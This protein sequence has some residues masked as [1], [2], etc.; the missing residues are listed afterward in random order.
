MRIGVIG[1]VHTQHRVLR[2]VLDA[3]ARQRIHY[4]LCAGDVVDGPGSVD[5]CCRL[6]RER[7]VRVVRGNHDRWFMSNVIRDLPLATERDAVSET[8][9][10]YLGELPPTLSFETPLGSLLLCH[11]LGEN[12]MGSVR[13]HDEG[14]ALATNDALHE[15]IAGPHA[16]VVNG[17]TH[18][19]M[20]RVFDGL[21]VINAGTLNPEQNP[22]FLVLDCERRAVEHH[23]VTADLRVVR[24]AEWPLAIGGAA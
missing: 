4:V 19:A 14:Y 3:L 9:R 15:L 10:A 24:A 1:D 22:C 11:G 12:D 13:H 18:H 17:H 2:A 5:E 7:Q 8:N 6:L 23:V 21:T 16:L 20:V